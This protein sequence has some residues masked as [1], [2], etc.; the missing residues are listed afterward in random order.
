MRNLVGG[1]RTSPASA[2]SRRRVTWRLLPPDRKNGR[3]KR[4]RII[5]I[6]AV[7]MAVVIA[8]VIGLYGRFADSTPPTPSTYL[9]VYTTGLPE[10][11]AGVSAFTAATGVRPG[12]VMYYSGWLERFQSGFAQEAAR[13][14]AVPL[15]QME[16]GGIS[17]AAI[18][19]GRYDAYLRSYA[20]SVKAF[21]GQV[22]LSFGHEMNGYWY[23]W[24]YRHTSPADFVAAWRHVVT[25]FRRQGAGNVAWLW[26]AN[27]IDVH[28]GIP[29]PARW[30]PGS[31]YVTM[32]GIDGY[33]LRPGWT[34]AS[35]FGPTIKAVRALTLD[36][37][38]ISETGA[39]NG[40]GQSAKVADLFTGI[41]AYGLL[42]FVWF[43]AVARHELPR[44]G[45]RDW[46][47]QGA[48]T[49]ATFHRG[50]QAYRRPS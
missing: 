22:I 45:L 12:L 20:A 21:G 40:P 3:K 11:Y 46:R 35:L 23:S 27:V 10:S 43:D 17:L 33:Y 15:V 2:V 1:R 50:A 39:P 5:A 13:H 37:I 31:S 44:N 41:R 38:L 8:L 18:A 30:W 7:A 49:F 34:F 25:V 48:A 42:G 4:T 26:T 14:G 6:A 36:K 24:G 9:G 16:P 32:V 19:A 47:L 28:G 29:S